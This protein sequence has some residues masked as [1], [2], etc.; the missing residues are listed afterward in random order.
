MN[1]APD[2]VPTPLLLHEMAFSLGTTAA[3]VAAVQLRVPDA[4]DYE[5]ATAAR[6]AERVDA[7]PEALEQL[8]R[9][10]AAR[11]VFR[12]LPD[13]RYAHTDASRL[14]RED[15][16]G[17][18]RSMVLLAGAPFAWQVWSH[19]TDAVRTGGSVCQDLFGT[20][21]FSHLE[22]NDPGLGALFDRAMSQSG[23]ATLRPVVEALRV[24][25]DVTV[26]D[27]GGGRGTLLRMLL[28][29]HPTALGVLFDLP[30]VVEGA[31][32]RLVDGD[33]ADRCRVLGGDAHRA[34]PVEA[35]L[36][37]LKNVVHMWD[38]TTAVGVL[39]SLVAAA[40]S[41]ARIV[42]VEQ[43]LDATRTLGSA[44][45]MDLL[46][47]ATQGGRERTTTGFTRLLEQAGL[48]AP[49]ITP[50]GPASF[51]VETTVP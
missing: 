45:T 16:P 12:A 37:L 26:A 28:E 15:T 4:L 36:Y 46:M 31:E 23:E 41:G 51:L 50:A 6:L 5:P 30:R 1:D 27:V 29:R 3:L 38:D 13:G 47:L 39:R 40:P 2:S 10:L 20:D 32:R 9:A 42:I 19:L 14:L 43:V 34:L 18:R 49:Q 21:L 17:S 48:P 44:T 8:L 22:K 25:E 11:D 33:L 7:H 24:D 35:D